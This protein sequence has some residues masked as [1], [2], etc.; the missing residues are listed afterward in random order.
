MDYRWAVRFS[1][2]ATPLGG[3]FMPIDLAFGRIPA[4]ASVA[5]VLVWI[6]IVTVPFAQILRSQYERIKGR[7]EGKSGHSS[8]RMRPFIRNVPFAPFPFAPFPD[9]LA[10]PRTGCER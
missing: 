8:L 2:G 6:G 10:G 7:R 3:I 1:L 9:C 4:A 5:M